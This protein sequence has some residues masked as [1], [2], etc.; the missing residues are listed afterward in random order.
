MN[1]IPGKSPGIPSVLVVL[2]VESI[3]YLSPCPE[4]VGKLLNL[5]K[6]CVDL[7]SLLFLSSCLLGTSPAASVSSWQI[8][9]RDC[10]TGARNK[11]YQSIPGSSWDRVLIPRASVAVWRRSCVDLREALGLF[12]GS[13]V[14]LQTA[15][16]LLEESIRRSRLFRKLFE[17]FAWKVKILSLSNLFYLTLFASALLWG[18]SWE[19]A[20]DSTSSG[21]SVNP[22]RLR[23]DV[24]KF[25]GRINFDMWRWEVMD[26][27]IASNL[28]DTLRLEKKRDS[29]TEEDW[30]MMNRT[31][32]DLIRSCLTQD[33]KYNV[34]HETSTRQLWEI[35]EKKYLMKSIESRLQL[36]S[37]FYH[38]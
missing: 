25:D 30:D 22:R 27:P 21:K 13:S 19:D 20:G 11:W 8:P 15:C 12:V 1:Y 5:V 33:I 6:Y 14:D 29:T 37:T 36:K 17:G 32:C 4:D 35:L 26:A 7:L 18:I 10:C 28:E 38:F 23:I 3:K 34:L 24:V 16:G 31:A 2:I 9:Q